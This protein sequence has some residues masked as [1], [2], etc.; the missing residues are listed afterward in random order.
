M[1]GMSSTSA[2]ATPRRAPA[3][4]K[5]TLP[6]II[7]RIGCGPAHMRFCLTGGGVY[8]VDGAELL[9]ITSVTKA[10]AD[11][12]GLDP[13]Q[14]AMGVTIVFVG[15]LIGNLICGPLGDRYGRRHL[16]IFSY[17]G[18]FIFSVLSSFVVDYNGF[19]L[20]RLL[21][22]F[23]FGIGQPAWNALATEV[24]PQYWRIAMNGASQTLFVAGELY[25][26]ALIIA[27]D[28]DMK[29]LHWR[30][31]LQ[32]GAIPSVLFALAACIFLLPSPSFLAL[33]GRSEEAKEVLDIMRHDNHGSSAPSVSTDFEVLPDNHV[34][35]H[36]FG[37]QL[38]AIFS[39][40]YLRS[41]LITALTCFGLNTLYYGSLYAFPQILPA[42]Q[43]HG[44]AGVQL[45]VG[46][47][48]EIPGN[49]AAVLLSMCM[50]RKPT[51]KLSLILSA[52]C[53][54]SFVVGTTMTPSAVSQALY[55][56][57][58]FGIKAV[59]G[60]G[61]V[62]TYQYAAEIFPTETR[63]TG[64]AFCIGS[65][66]LGAM[67]APLLYE[68]VLDRFHGYSGFFYIL[69]GFCVFNCLLID[70]LPFETA[71]KT[72]T[73]RLVQDPPSSSD[74]YGSV[75]DARVP[76]LDLEGTAAAAKPTADGEVATGPRTDVQDQGEARGG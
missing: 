31:L 38:K 74:S 27:D 8:F 17:V 42:L 15:V 39:P 18:V 6:A 22:G 12:W 73:E 13:W 7:E 69:S 32:L 23:S 56:G 29:N 20:W 65:G 71:E 63:A 5:P 33:R 68:L 30:R 60:I 62:V 35:E 51:M 43:G 70:F 61:Y 76:E 53:L 24:T 2:V 14:R 44:S 46:A 48:W 9:L 4:P 21:V 41:T 1:P 66:R 45:L 52:T 3:S 47:L 28:P 75:R 49:A 72:F 36:A 19:C 67:T 57:G 37:Y 34:R 58:Y 16:I 26:A 50:P 59:S 11:D 10:V 55:R 40:Y 25:S 54:L 64:T